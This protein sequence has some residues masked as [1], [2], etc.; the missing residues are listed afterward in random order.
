MI[1]L[2]KMLFLK[3][4]Y[5]IWSQDVQREVDNIYLLQV[6]QVTENWYVCFQFFASKRRQLLVTFAKYFVLLNGFNSSKSSQMKSKTRKS[7]N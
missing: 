3:R 7:M 2:K 6:T 4:Y 5:K 1:N